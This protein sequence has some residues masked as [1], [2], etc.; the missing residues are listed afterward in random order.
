MSTAVVSA[1]TRRMSN[2]RLL[3]NGPRISCGDYLVE[4][5]P[6]FLRPEASVS[7]MR[8]LGRTFA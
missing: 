4:H 5:Y 8:L 2:L 6:T 7:C 3:S 1:E